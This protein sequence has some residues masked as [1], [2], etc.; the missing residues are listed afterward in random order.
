MDR[1]TRTFKAIDYLLDRVTTNPWLPDGSLAVDW[2]LDIMPSL[3]RGEQATV[4]VA[5][6]LYNG[7]EYL[8]T[9]NVL[10][11]IMDWTDTV[12]KHRIL[13]ALNYVS[14]LTPELD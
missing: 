7:G 1:H 5:L 8:Q 10:R 14:H 4:E 11:H 2:L 6:T 13:K 3:S 9:G 12:F